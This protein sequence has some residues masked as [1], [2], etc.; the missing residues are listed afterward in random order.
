MEGFVTFAPPGEPKQSA[1]ELV[2]SVVA[3]R[4][5]EAGWQFHMVGCSSA[6]THFAP[7][8]R[9]TQNRPNACIQISN[10]QRSIT[11]VWPL[12]TW[13]RTVTDVHSAPKSGE[14]FH[15][16]DVLQPLVEEFVHV[17]LNPLAQA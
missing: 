1:E 3:H 6:Q 11:D 17:A 12:F 13:S 7:K 5:L 15:G 9:T 14:T 4:E 16:I 8:R 2:L 10:P